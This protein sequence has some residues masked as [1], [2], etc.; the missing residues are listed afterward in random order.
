VI[1]RRSFLFRLGLSWAALGCNAGDSAKSGGG[2]A[3]ASYCAAVCERQAA[4]ASGSA[5]AGCRQLCEND[6]G[7]SG[8]RGEL[9]E[10]QA[11]CIA[12][13]TCSEWQGGSAE[14]DCF[15]LAIGALAPSD[16]C[17][18]FC[19]SDAAR[20]FECG[21]GYSIMDCVRGPVCAYKDE[22]LDAAIACDS[23]LDC[24]ARA[25]CVSAALEAL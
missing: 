18:S 4:C 14:S 3:H 1:P 19:R 15:A 24:S 6:P 10:L 17:I 9:W 7:A 25:S 23:E 21:G 12:A 2:P 16:T 11:A 20:S 13:L 5:A 22:L 8:P